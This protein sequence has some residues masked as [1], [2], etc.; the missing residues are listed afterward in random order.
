MAAG[1]SRFQQA[2]RKKLRLRMAID[3]PS[4]TGKTYTALRFAFTLAGDT[5]RV[6][7]IDTEHGSASKYEGESPDGIPFNFGVLELTNYAPTEYTAAIQEA[8]REGFDVLVID[9]LSHAWI[10]EGGALDLKDK[11]GGNSFTAWAKITPMQRKMVDSILASPCHI[12][13][14]MRSKTEYVLETNDRGQQVPRKIGM[15]PLQRDGM[16]YEFDVYGSMDWSHTLTITKSR[17][18]AVADA[19]SVK[20]GATFMQPIM[21]WLETG[22]TMPVQKSDA[23]GLAER[24][25]ARTERYY[26][27]ISQLNIRRQ[28]ATAAMKRKY[29]VE[30]FRMLAESQADEIVQALEGKLDKQLN[31]TVMTSLT[32][33]EKD[34]ATD[35]G[36]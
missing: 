10:G 33:L 19:V 6:A 29:A 30:D 15:A 14:T 1:Q 12:I 22:K 13:A 32:G 25:K 28:D 16:E 17:C 26:A 23:D 21:T 18:S 11:Q 36:K 27:L 5:G 24:W 8:G 20:P 2:T 3:G 31:A 9:S 35:N 7:V 34:L 4:G